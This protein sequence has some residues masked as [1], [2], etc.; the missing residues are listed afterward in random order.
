MEKILPKN[1][2]IIDKNGKP[3]MV[4]SPEFSYQLEKEREDFESEQARKSKKHKKRF[5]YF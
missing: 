3:K 1:K 5:Q 2:L 4:F